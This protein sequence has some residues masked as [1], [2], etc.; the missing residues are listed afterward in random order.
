M[1][2]LCSLEA[3]P[4]LLKRSSI[5][6][7][8]RVFLLQKARAEGCVSPQ[9]SS[10]MAS[11]SGRALSLTYGSLG[12]QCPGRTT[13]F[14]RA[15][16]LFPAVCRIKFPLH[17]SIC[18]YPMLATGTWLANIIFCIR[19]VSVGESSAHWVGSIQFVFFWSLEQLF[20][21]SSLSFER[22][23]GLCSRQG[24]IFF[25]LHNYEGR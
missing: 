22:S 10:L 21:R 9:P 14:L 20:W 13:L 16:L 7:R 15:P 5:Q 1:A 18:F 8:V 4:S 2:S 25:Q 23:W 17:G 3:F 11:R 19:S 6:T 24:V 12:T